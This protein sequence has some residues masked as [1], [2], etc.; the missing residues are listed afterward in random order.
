[1]VAETFNPRWARDVVEAQISHGRK[2]PDKFT[3]HRDEGGIIYG[4]VNTTDKV[5]SSTTFYVDRIR[6]RLAEEVGPRA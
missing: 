2:M 3:V 4:T 5:F 1:M 6:E